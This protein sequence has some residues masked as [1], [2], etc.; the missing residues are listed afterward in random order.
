M[1]T[2]TKKAI[3]NE[4]IEEMINFGE[5]YLGQAEIR[6]LEVCKEYKALAKEVEKRFPGSVLCWNA[7]TGYIWIK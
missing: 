7:E 3:Q 5:S 4:L 2:M 1:S 6:G